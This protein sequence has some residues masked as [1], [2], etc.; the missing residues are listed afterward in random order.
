MRRRTLTVVGFGATVAACALVI[1]AA[2]AGQFAVVITHGASMQPTYGAGD[3]VVVREAGTYAVGD[4]VAYHSPML[5]QIVLHRIVD[6]DGDAFVL[7]GDANS[8][9]DPERPR[10][11][12]LL[13]TA[14]L[15]APKVGVPARWL[16]AHPALAAAGL[17]LFV[18]ATGPIR[19]KR[20][21]VKK[22]PGRASPRPPKAFAAGQSQ[23]L[24][25]LLAA[26][27]AFGLLAGV[28]WTRPVT[29]AGPV[30]Y[31]HHG[32]FIYSASASTGAVYEAARVRTGDPLFLNLVRDIRLGFSYRF[33]AEE[34]T[35]TRGTI[36]LRAEVTNGSGWSRTLELAATR[37]FDGDDVA[38]SGNL[39]VA[40]IRALTSQVAEATGES[41]TI[42]V[43]VQPE[44]TLVGDV[45]EETFEE[46]FAPSLAYQLTDTQL[47]PVDGDDGDEQFRAEQSGE[48][49][50]PGRQPA[51]LS[52]S[53]RAIEVPTARWLSVVA[54]AACVA[55]LLTLA[56]GSRRLAGLSEAERIR[57]RWPDL[58]TAVQVEHI[59]PAR[60]VCVDD[61]NALVALAQ[62]SNRLILHDRATGAFLVELD[63]TL[64]RYDTAAAGRSR[65]AGPT[66]GDVLVRARTQAAT[67]M[68][69]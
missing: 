26:L 21:T 5:D 66:D 62:R 64:Y 60:V 36:G 42:T 58:V 7:Q 33:S 39:D 15:H 53:G 45:G 22:P 25:A 8:W 14:W 51:T 29:A 61:M 47:R 4:I 59:L 40:R 37:P 12:D 10:A 9:L 28:S 68:E 65:A 52:W 41:G 50:V 35:A 11:D 48:V 20:R 44:V 2:L 16:T 19:R 3:V 46:R 18:V 55:A 54:A 57:R 38:T 34:P 49:Q 56:I 24:A 1:V 13:G 63:A 31:T 27:F 23:V 17:L 43:T 67:A 6:T 30:G 69:G 32:Q